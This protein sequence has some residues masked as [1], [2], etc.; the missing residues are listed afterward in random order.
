MSGAERAS[1]IGRP[2][3]PQGIWATHAAL[4]V[5]QVAFGSIPVEGKL[6]MMPQAAGGEGIAPEAIAMARMIGAAIFFQAVGSMLARRS[7]SGERPRATIR[8]QGMLVVLSVLGIVAT[9]TF[10]IFGVRIT[11]PVS[12]ALLAVTIPVVTAAMAVA[13]RQ[14]RPSVRLAIGLLLA[15]A[16]AAILT[17]IIG[18]SGPGGLD[19]GAVLIVMNALVY[20]AYLVLG[21]GIIQRLGA[22]EVL[23]WI[24]TWGAVLF[25]PF[26]LPSLLHE[27]PVLTE[28]GAWLLG[29]L[30]VVSTIIGYL[31]NAWALGRST[32]TLV[33]IY[34]YLQPIIAAALAYVQLRQPIAPHALVA[35]ALILSGV[36][37]V[38]TRF[39]LGVPRNRAP[40]G[41]R[42]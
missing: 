7:S 30:V 1:E 16:G 3:A 18:G 13:V 22:I 21:R 27:L 38:A 15:S 31:A 32:A 19:V 6:A 37:L 35:G 28:R 4:I 24:F 41:S 34:I 29:Y 11:T 9:Q 14:E 36:T 33:T 23:R 5:V 39:S 2:A 42:P 10:L 26:G 17:G 25:A 40:R 20:S 12:A 8:D